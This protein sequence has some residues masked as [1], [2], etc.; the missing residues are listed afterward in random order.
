MKSA[1]KR[2]VA[3]EVNSVPSVFTCFLILLGIV[4]FFVL[5]C[6]LACF[7]GKMMDFFYDLFNLH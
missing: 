2:N 6:L 5:F 1:P 7:V 3:V 4:G